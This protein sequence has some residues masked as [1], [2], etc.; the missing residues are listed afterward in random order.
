MG[1]YE[2]AL[3]AVSFEWS[4]YDLARVVEKR[5]CTLPN[6]RAKAFEYPDGGFR[7]WVYFG[8]EAKALCLLWVNRQTRP[9]GWAEMW[10]YAVRGE[11]PRREWRMDVVALVLLG[12]EIYQIRPSGV[13]LWPEESP[14]K[15][16]NPGA[17]LR[18]FSI[19]LDYIREVPR[20]AEPPSTVWP[21]PVMFVQDKPR[22]AYDKDI[23]PITLAYLVHVT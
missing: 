11:R 6:I 3:V 5:F 15:F 9:E 7:I 8:D 1:N 14:E 4:P 2:P 13:V 18:A 21:L 20:Y 16:K 12:N 23:A 19:L 10:T 17:V 22:T